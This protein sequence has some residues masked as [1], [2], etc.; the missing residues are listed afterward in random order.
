MRKSV[1]KTIVVLVLAIILSGLCLVFTGC[2][3]DKEPVYEI[4]L[5]DD[6]WVEL[7]KNVVGD[8]FALYVKYDGT[9]KGCN[10]K[11]FIDDEEFYTYEYLNPVSEHIS[12]NPLS[13][14]FTNRTNEDEAGYPI[15]RGQCNVHYKFD[16][17]KTHANY[18]TA[19][20]RQIAQGDLPR[21]V[22][23]QIKLFIE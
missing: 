22:Y 1:V 8:Y 17:F 5:Y 6:N 21:D 13:I 9:K 10:V 3:G 20:G 14:W 11:C 19:S 15:E 4:K 16:T 2:K 7:E 18:W 23:K 12:P